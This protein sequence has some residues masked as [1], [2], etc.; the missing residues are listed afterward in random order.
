MQNTYNF[1]NLKKINLR[2][3]SLYK[4]NGILFEV[5]EK[6]N[7]GVYCLAGANGLG[8]TTFLNS[9]NYCLT[10]IVL[11]PNKQVLSPSEIVKSYKDYTKR[12][13]V[14]RIH[15]KDKNQAEIEVTF[16]VSDK[17]YRLVR[18]FFER[19]SLRVLEIYKLE[20]LKKISLVTGDGLSPIELNELYQ[21][22]LSSDIGFV[23][24][25]YFIF[26]QLYVLTF[27]ENRNMIF[28]DERASSSALA[29]AFNSN[30]EDA[31]KISELIRRMEKHE[32]NGRNARWQATQAKTKFKDLEKEIKDKK[33][34]NLQKLEDELNELY[35]NSDKSEKTY[36]NIKIEYDSILKQQSYLNSE[37]MILKN[38]HT[39]Y[40][41]KYS[42]PRSKLVDNS[43][44]QFA[45]QKKECL[46]CGSSGAHI[47][48]N[49]ERNIHKDEC[50][51]C[52]TIIND[53]NNTEQIE[54][55][56]LIETN[57][58]IISSKSQELE[59]LILE[60]NGKIDQL[61]KAE[62]EYNRNKEK[63]NEFLTD[64]PFISYK[65]SGNKNLESLIKQYKSQYELADRESISE[66]S[67]RDKLKPE[68]D[69]LLDKVETAYKD[70]ELEFVPIFKK[71]AKSFIGLDL[72]I[73]PKRVGKSI[74]LVLEIQNT[75]RT[76]SFQLSESQRFFLDIALR[77]SLAI[78]LSGSDGAT[79]LIDTPEGSLDIA[80]E[81]R[82]G[83]M[84][85]KFVMEY[86]QN[87]IMTANINASQLLISLAKEC[88]S[89]NMKVR[90]M[91]DW[92]D[93][94]EIQKEGEGL[95]KMAYDR[96]EY[97]LNEKNN[98]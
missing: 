5:D 57:D 82:V 58:K 44:I 55:L 23:N 37:I 69:S 75:A 72:N 83:N 91:L 90:R 8:K 40:F 17:Y 48:E 45:I 30:P 19:E 88:G 71:L 31:E 12:Y 26:Y 1:I 28:W 86:H 39:R 52:D 63:L 76:E 15:E 9:I 41:S 78:F 32:S 6:I 18:G 14:G 7:K 77:M 84:F 92:T 4:K 43:N 73:Q 46:V 81:S 42:K 98:V 60:M 51:L 87:L 96:I 29:V 33:P 64:N 97:A 85:G 80:Y 59:N 38:D 70:A 21:K 27:D 94:S 65:G 35:N 49:I 24:F 13:Y 11:E 3:F 67:K 93:L 34:A 79:M 54:L 66:Y 2:N 89:S 53:K 25:D 68:Y 61:E 16:K 62:F 22:S 36:N 50:P 95:F 47:R 56:E 10:G 20:G 74:K